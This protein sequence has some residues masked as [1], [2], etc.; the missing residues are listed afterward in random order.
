MSADHYD[1]LVAAAQRSHRTSSTSPIVL[2]A[3]RR[4]EMDPSQAASDDLMK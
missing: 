2:E 4:A 3:V 1:W